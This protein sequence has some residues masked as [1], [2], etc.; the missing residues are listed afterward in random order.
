LFPSL[1]DIV[2]DITKYTR[3]RFLMVITWKPWDECL[4]Y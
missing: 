3:M 2:N 1:D 4:V